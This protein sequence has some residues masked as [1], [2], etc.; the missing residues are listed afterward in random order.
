MS[1]KKYWDEDDTYGGGRP[2][3]KDYYEKYRHRLYDYADDEDDLNY[4]DDIEYDDDFG[5]YEDEK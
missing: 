2:V 4:G 1:R 3:E 5:D